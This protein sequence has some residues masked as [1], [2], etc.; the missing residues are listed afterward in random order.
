MIENWVRGME[1]PNFELQK[2]FYNI[3]PTLYH[4]NIYI[5]L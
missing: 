5:L 3:L 4:D 2:T 1:P